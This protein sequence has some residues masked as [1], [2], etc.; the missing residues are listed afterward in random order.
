MK[1]IIL[2]LVVCCIII[3]FAI[4]AFTT[5]ERALDKFSEQLFNLKLPGKTTL[6][7]KRNISGKL[8]GNG[9]GMDFLACI[10]LETDLDINQLKNYYESIEFENAKKG[11]D[12]PPE[13]H[14]IG[15]QSNRLETEYLEHGDIIFSSLDEIFDFEKY[16][17]VLIYDGG[18][19]TFDIRGH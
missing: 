10:L 2:T 17:A 15:V 13:V 7:E 8:N 9:N 12:F 11:H 19:I 6:I 18:Y 5:N 3:G 4:M 1:E 14:V 16:F